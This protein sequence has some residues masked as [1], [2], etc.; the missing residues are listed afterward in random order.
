M[1]TMYRISKKTAPSQSGASPTLRRTTQK[2][3]VAKPIFVSLD[4][5]DHPVEYGRL[6]E[7]GLSVSIDLP[8]ELGRK[9]KKL[10]AID[11]KFKTSKSPAEKAARR[12]WSDEE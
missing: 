11:Y 3:N 4:K 6:K 12:V 7:T 2:Q 10:L 5:T 1:G 8:D 9:R